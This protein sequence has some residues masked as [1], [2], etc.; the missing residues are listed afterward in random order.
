[1]RH[2]V[3]SALRS[4]ASLS[5][6]TKEGKPILRLDALCDRSVEVGHSWSDVGG[7]NTLAIERYCWRIPCNLTPQRPSLGGYP[8]YASFFPKFNKLYSPENSFL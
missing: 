8:L 4:S 2:H 5:R 3:R 7:K 6:T 1:M